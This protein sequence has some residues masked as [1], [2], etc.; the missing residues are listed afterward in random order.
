MSLKFKKY[1]SGKGLLRDPY[2]H[3]RR[4]RLY[5]LRY[6]DGRGVADSARE[7]YGEVYE[8]RVVPGI[9]GLTF[10]FFVGRQGGIRMRHLPTHVPV[11]ESFGRT[12]DP[13]PH[14][15]QFEEDHPLHDD[16]VV[17]SIDSHTHS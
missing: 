1:A 5:T 17:K 15:P 11:P 3:Q 2:N 16:E 12:R 8:D 13:F 6:R 10:L 7:V 4:L 14:L 9:G